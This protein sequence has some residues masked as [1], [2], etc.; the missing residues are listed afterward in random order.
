MLT[1]TVENT[2]DAYGKDLEVRIYGKADGEFS[3][4]EDDGKTFNYEKG[5][6]RVRKLTIS[7][8]SKTGKEEVIIDKAPKMFGN[9][10]KWNFMTK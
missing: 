6:F 3:L 7:Q 1:E 4:Y 10:T 2:K 9:I 5:E 8:S